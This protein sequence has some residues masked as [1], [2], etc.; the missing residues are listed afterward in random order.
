MCGS[1]TF[2]VGST[3]VWCLWGRWT[4]LRYDS[5]WFIGDKRGPASQRCGDAR[6]VLFEL[7][8]LRVYFVR[9]AVR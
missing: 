4:G 3:R 8:W 6:Y 5:G 7:G 1:M 9:A 2:K